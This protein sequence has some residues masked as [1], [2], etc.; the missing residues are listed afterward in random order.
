MFG[1]QQPRLKPIG[2]RSALLRIHADLLKVHAKTYLF[3]RYSI[4][5]LSLFEKLVIALEDRRFLRH[6]GIDWKSVVRELVKFVTFQKHGG[7]S[8]I[9]M[10]FVRTAT[11]YRKR[12]LRRK[13]YELILATFIQYR[14]SK[15]EILRAYVRCAFFGSRL[16]GAEAASNK[17]FGLASD[18][19]SLDQAA[20]LAAMLVYPRP[21]RET[22]LWRSN[23]V[24][25]ANYG[26]R[27]YVANKK[28][29]DQIPG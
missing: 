28:S 27:V 2:L 11:G 3:D 17:I 14:Y 25:R 13:A 22:D 4:D 10:Q 26:V 5:R 23:V 21:L 12:T 29:F 1:N 24:R 18:R 8:T 9:D 16:I 6:A 7:A 19:L 15:V 20:F